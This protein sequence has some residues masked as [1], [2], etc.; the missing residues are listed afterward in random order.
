MQTLELVAEVAVLE[1]EVVRL[2]EKVV[3]FRQEAAHI[4]SSTTPSPCHD[5]T[6]ELPIT[7]SKHK[8][9]RASSQSEIDTG[10]SLSRIAS[11]RK[12]ASLERPSDGSRKPHQNDRILAFDTQSERD[13]NSSKSLPVKKH[14]YTYIHSLF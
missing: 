11:S 6:P 1:E 13:T 5:T 10:S 8:H 7:T 12:F 3:N 9:S 4:S 2:E 14:V